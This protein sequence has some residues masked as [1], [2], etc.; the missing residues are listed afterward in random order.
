MA[1]V[2]Y[3][4]GCARKLRG[5]DIERAL[6]EGRAVE[7]QVPAPEQPR[8][9]GQVCLHNALTEGRAHRR[10]NAAGRGRV[11]AVPGQDDG[12]H[13]Q[14][15]RRPYDRADVAGV[16]HALEHDGA[17]HAL[18]RAPLGQA[19]GEHRSGAV[20]HRRGVGHEF[21]R[22]GVKPR[23]LRDAARQAPLRR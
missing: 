4:D 13:A 7:R 1:L 23:A 8:K 10:A 15:V 19:H 3:G 11:C 2:A 21:R 9:A 14:R 17:L 12:V 5:A 16:L 6:R 18:R 20:L 22:C